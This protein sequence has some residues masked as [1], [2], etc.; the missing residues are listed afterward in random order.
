MANITETTIS[1]LKINYL[2]EEQYSNALANGEINENE[3]YMTPSND[4]GATV[5]IPTFTLNGTTLT[6][7]TT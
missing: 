7:T 6:I 5:N 2:T 3:I 1:E 4:S